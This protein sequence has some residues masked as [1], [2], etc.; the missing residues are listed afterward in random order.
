MVFAV[1][2]ALPLL[3]LGLVLTACTTAPRVRSEAAPDANLQQYRTYGFFDKL[4]TDTQGYTTLTTRQLRT[5]IAREMEARGY[6]LSDTP[7]LQINFFVATKDKIEGTTGPRVGV[8]YGHGRWSRG[9][10]T[11]VGIGSRD[12]RNYTEGSLTIDLVDRAKN[13]LVW[14]GV[15][16]SRVTRAALEKPE[17]AVNTAVTAI[18]EKYP[19]EVVAQQAATSVP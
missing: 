10:G 5:A 2:R 1:T 19:R 7:D 16:E 12:L 17:A 3:A 15:A 8:S 14:R 13:E 9:W 6:T 18:F 4:G 11:A